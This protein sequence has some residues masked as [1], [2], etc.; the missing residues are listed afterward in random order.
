V[1][2]LRNAQVSDPLLRHLIGSHHGRGRPWLPAAP[3][4]N[5]YASID[6]DEWPLQFARLQAQ[7]GL[8]GLAFLEALVRLA[9]WQQSA[10]E[11]GDQ[12]SD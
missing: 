2:S 9:D 11:Q 5:L 4:P 10:Q 7:H 3:D 8:W 12:W 1:A 6:G